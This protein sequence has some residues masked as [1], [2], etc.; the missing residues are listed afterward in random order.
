MSQTLI[1]LRNL[2]SDQIRGLIIKRLPGLYDNVFQLCDATVACY[3]KV[4]TPLP[5]KTNE[6]ITYLLTKIWEGLESDIDLK[7]LDINDQI[8]ALM[9][10]YL[11]KKSDIILTEVFSID[12]FY[13][14]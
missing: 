11:C 4:K 8:F 6:A 13:S 14:D 12:H 2:S 9:Q 1:A 7:Q 5:N 10:A 3:S